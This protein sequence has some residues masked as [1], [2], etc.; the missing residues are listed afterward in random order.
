MDLKWLKALLIL[1]FLIAIICCLT[2]DIF[3]SS[4]GKTVFF[5]A[6]GLAIVIPVIMNL[7]RPKQYARY[8]NLLLPIWFCTMWYSSDFLQKTL[9]VNQRTSTYHFQQERKAFIKQNQNSITSEIKRIEVLIAADTFNPNQETAFINTY[10]N[11]NIPKDT[12]VAQLY[13][14]TGTW[15]SVR[16]IS[17]DFKSKSF[18]FRQTEGYVLKSFTV[19]Y[20]RIIELSLYNPQFKESPY[21]YNSSIYFYPYGDVDRSFF[22]WEI[23]DFGTHYYLKYCKTRNYVFED[24]WIFKVEGKCFG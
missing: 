20:G 10:D 1:A 14:G 5:S 17:L 21:F 13:R 15:Q 19:K 7:L 12:I 9:F 8:L 11:D 23:A 16:L 6:T 24:K 3:G 18:N 4:A 22:I 2:V